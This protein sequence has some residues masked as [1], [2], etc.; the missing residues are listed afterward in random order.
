MEKKKKWPL[1][2]IFS[3]VVLTIY[4]ILPTIFYY[5][6]PLK[7]PISYEEGMKTA[8]SIANRLNAMEGDAIDWLDSYC[9]LLRLKPSSIATAKNNPQ[10]IRI[11]FAKTDDAE[12]LRSFSRAPARSF[13][14]S[15]PSYRSFRMKTTG[16]RS[17]CSAGFPRKLPIRRLTVI[18]LSLRNLLTTARSLPCIQT[19]SST[20]PPR[21]PP[22]LEA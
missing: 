4:N 15:P 18:F 14:S 7:A 12:R 2:L 8:S 6:Q 20:A 3:V 21:S 13:H 19:S 11:Q 1:V 16:K 5:A 22:P 10:L 17:S 9:N